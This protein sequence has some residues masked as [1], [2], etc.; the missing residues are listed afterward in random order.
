MITREMLKLKH[1]DKTNNVNK[2]L[3]V[4][5]TALKKNAFYIILVKF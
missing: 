4:R 2:L 1:F 3:N 5:Y